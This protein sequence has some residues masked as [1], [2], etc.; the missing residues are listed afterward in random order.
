[1]TMSLHSNTLSHAQ[2]VVQLNNSWAEPTSTNIGFA[3]DGSFA[4]CKGAISFDIHRSDE[5]SS[6]KAEIATVPDANSIPLLEPWDLDG[7]AIAPSSYEVG[8]PNG[9][10]DIGTWYDNGTVALGKY[11]AN[12]QLEDVEDI[13]ATGHESSSLALFRVAREP[14]HSWHVSQENVVFNPETASSG[15]GLTEASTHDSDS[16]CQQELPHEIDLCPPGSTLLLNPRD[17][18]LATVGAGVG[19]LEFADKQRRW[20]TQFPFRNH[21]IDDTS[22]TD[23]GALEQ[24]GGGPGPSSIQGRDDVDSDILQTEDVSEAST[25]D[26]TSDTDSSVWMS[27]YS[28]V[29]PRFEESNPFFEVK[30]HV[31]RHVLQAFQNWSNQYSRDGVRQ[32]PNT[33]T[34]PGGAA[35]TSSTQTSTHSGGEQQRLNSDRKRSRQNGNG[36]GEE[37]GGDDGD[38][39]DPPRKKIRSS[40][41]SCVRAVSLACPYA[42]KDPI[43][44]RGCYS[45]VLKRTQDVKQHLSRCHQ[46]PIYC[47]RCLNEFRTEEARDKHSRATLC[48]V[49]QGEPFEGVTRD[50]KEQLTQRLSR[51]MALEEQWFTIFDILFPGHTPRPKS[52]YVNADL[53]IEL[54][55]F[56][57][58][59]FAEGPRILMETIQRHGMQLNRPIENEEHNLAALEQTIL[60]EGLQAIARRWTESLAQ[61]Q[62]GVGTN[63][64]DAMSRA[65]TSCAEPTSEPSRASS[66]TLIETRRAREANATHLASLQEENNS[67]PPRPTEDNSLEN[68]RQV[69]PFKPNHGHCLSATNLTSHSNSESSR[70]AAPSSIRMASLSHSQS[71]MD[72]GET[73]TTGEYDLSQDFRDMFQEGGNAGDDIMDK[74]MN[75]DGEDMTWPSQSM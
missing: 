73:T 75:Y 1:M 16:V 31:L 44:Y 49:E 9:L 12:L 5:T 41:Q 68:T 66:V 24:S 30:D 18:L 59:M 52:A 36:K 43:R 62:G 71:H 17:L 23:R 6:I 64:S 28:E 25:G 11:E 34:Q 55:A 40:K 39:P 21:S 3:K 45:N 37:D 70:V 42:K 53:S 61:H 51:K 14:Q 48:E 32:R 33:A 4:A 26:D 74:Y 22:D 58:M 29:G 19:M 47:S 54:E 27:D 8:G 72:T 46:L 65:A 57:D 13:A 15:P 35:P 60:A 63:G 67:L 10:S 38:G 2:G 56:Q 50:Q 7:S 20:D 69:S